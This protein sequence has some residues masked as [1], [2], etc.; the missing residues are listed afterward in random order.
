MKICYS[1]IKGIGPVLYVKLK[2]KYGICFCHRI[3]ER[4]INFLGLENF[5]CS[6]CLG[7]FLGG[8]IGSFLHFL[9]YHFNLVIVFFLMLPLLIDGFTQFFGLRESNNI[10]RIITGFLY[11]VS[12]NFV[13]VLI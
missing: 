10:L 13:G 5:L 9:G 3:E 4:T 8:L 11:G 7:I 1:W 6:R 12:L 2:K